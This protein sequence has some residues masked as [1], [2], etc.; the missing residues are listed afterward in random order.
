[1]VSKAVHT[2]AAEL[3]RYHDEHLSNGDYHLEE[4][5]VHGEFVGLLA[6]E[7]GLSRRPIMKDDPRFRAFAELDIGT[8]SGRKLERPRKSERHAIEFAYSAPKSASIA[9]TH[10]T[11]IAGELASAI[12]EELKWFEGFACC[13]DR[14]GD[15]K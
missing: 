9:A 2:S 14:R 8:L 4:G 6:E 13:R 11:R 1:M 7:W 3:M 15:G 12:K 10:D 5:K